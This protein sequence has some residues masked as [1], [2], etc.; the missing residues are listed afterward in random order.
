MSETILQPKTY[1]VRAPT[2]VNEGNDLQ[3]SHGYLVRRDM[4]SQDL[5]AAS[6]KKCSP[7]ALI[8]ADIV[9]GVRRGVQKWG[10]GRA[11]KQGRGLLIL[12]DTASSLCIFPSP[13]AKYSQCDPTTSDP[14]LLMAP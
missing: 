12:R 8:N 13:I 11:Q 6:Q 3:D 14:W 5:T 10:D 7:D 2:K 1:Q 9:Q 4:K